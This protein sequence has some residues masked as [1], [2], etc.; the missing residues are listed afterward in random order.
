MP[1][2][3]RTK[4][5][6]RPVPYTPDL[7]GRDPLHEA[8]KAA[9]FLEWFVLD[10]HKGLKV[11][12]H[13]AGVLCVTNVVIFILNNGGH[14]LQQQRLLFLTCSRVIKCALRCILHTCHCSNTRQQGFEAFSILQ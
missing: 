6:K 9:E 3:S 12:T 11:G 8:Q 1:G 5:T 13:A 10:G 7:N 2:S 14:D 4:W